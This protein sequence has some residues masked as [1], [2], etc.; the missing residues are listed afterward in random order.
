MAFG[1]QSQ[2]SEGITIAYILIVCGFMS[3]E[4]TVIYNGKYRLYSR[5]D[6]KMSVPPFDRVRIGLKPKE[7]DFVILKIVCLIAMS[8]SQIS[9]G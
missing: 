7:H 2:R 6:K 1:N 9:Y 8:H 3:G 4:M 5:D